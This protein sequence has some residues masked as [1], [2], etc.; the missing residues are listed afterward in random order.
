[1]PFMGVIPE[2]PSF[3][4]SFARTFTEGLSKGVGKAAD[5]TQKMMM[6]QPK[7]KKPLGL[8]GYRD[9]NKAIETFAPNKFNDE[10]K[11]EIT[12]LY[13]QLLS[14]N[15]DV[16]ETEA[17]QYVID[18]YSNA[19]KDGGKTPLSKNATP[20]EQA[21][22]DTAEGPT[23]G[24]LGE[25]LEPAY[26]TAK[27]HPEQLAKELPVAGSKSL[28]SLAAMQDPVQLL[29]SLFSG[30][31]P[32]QPSQVISPSLREGLSEEEK[33]GAERIAETESFLMDMFGPSLGKKLLN[34]IKGTGA[35]AAEFLSAEQGAGK[36]VG[37]GK[38]ILKDAPSLA[39]E[40]AAESGLAG[41]ASEANNLSG[42]TKRLGEGI[43]FK[44]SKG[45]SYT[46]HS[47]GS[48][49]RN[50]AARPE[51]PGD[52]GLQTKSEK[53][54]FLSPEE[55]EKL[56]ALQLQYPKTKLINKDGYIAVQQIEGANAGKI[57]KDTVV[58]AKKS[59]EVGDTPLEIWD[60]GNSHH[61]GNKITEIS[62]GAPKEATQMRIE[63]LDPKSKFY[64]PQDQAKLR[65]MQLK[66]I[67]QYEVEIAADEA[68]R[69]ARAEAKEP[70][71]AVGLAGRAKRAETAEAR[72]PEVQKAYQK[73][74]ARV[75]ALEDEVAGLSGVRKEQ[76]EEIL[77]AAV[78]EL[79]NAQFELMQAVEN[80]KGKSFRAGVEKM[81]MAA[82]EK[83]QKISEAVAAGEEV[84]LAKMDYSPDLIKEAKK[85]S[86]SR[87]LTSNKID[88]FY[89]QVHD[90]YANQYRQR[91]A[92]LDQEMAAAMEQKSMAGLHQRQQIEKERMAIRKLIDSAEAENTIHRHK[93]ALRE[94]QQRK[95]AS[96]RFKKLK[97]SSGSEKAK[98]AFSQKAWKE[99]IE[100]AGTPQARAKIVVEGAEEVAAQNPSNAA[101][102]KK[103]GESLSETIKEIAEDTSKVK[104]L[105]EPAKAKSFG[106]AFV[107]DLKE[108]KEKFPY[109][110]KSRL[111]KD[112]L[113]G[114][115]TASLDDIKK[116]LDIDIPV[117]A[118][119]VASLVIGRGGRG[120]SIRFIVNGI[121]KAIIKKAKINSAVDAYNQSDMKKFNEYP[122]SIQKKAKEKIRG[123]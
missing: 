70:K 43:T 91:L 110:W 5:F 14:E 100:S 29:A 114:V 22:H 52:H 28:E 18:Q 106:E 111:G 113:I 78:K 55:T 12:K 105:K 119:Q 93:L 13:A 24:M 48:T 38:E 118:G 25:F 86:K 26:E 56:D 30:K 77:K 90:T 69:L 75:R 19:S 120:R 45:S 7:A 107:G 9:A 115:G 65:E 66:I 88:D 108:F 101:K 53:T 50:K 81:E 40:G 10:H 44:T 8:R 11:S 57:I 84:T 109:F 73:A 85:I 122:A 36:A 3:G 54:Y 82:Q 32:L 39:G 62:E 72:L 21:R 15:P 2:I 123:F 42:R 92:Q 116:E 98:E 83:M 49:T 59:P 58:K 96:E 102:I 41:S 104:D 35:K 16:D 80:L 27:K 71:T 17:L 117:S 31:K 33:E 121:T 23:F 51:H 1:M 99:K 47:D 95:L 60:D 63:R 37:L 76:G 67:P 61:F 79:D 68:A 87:K 20:L 4:R 97:P 112:L 74:V 94:M 64:K 89:T 103:E 46:L 34:A 6:R